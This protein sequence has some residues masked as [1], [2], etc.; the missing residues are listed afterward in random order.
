MDAIDFFL[1][2]YRELHRR[3]TDDLLTTSDS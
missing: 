2:R 3:L 1:L